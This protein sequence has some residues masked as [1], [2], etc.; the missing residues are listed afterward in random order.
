MKRLFNIFV[1]SLLPLVAVVGQGSLSG[2]NIYLNPGHG[3]FD[4]N[5]RSCWTIPVPSEWTDSAGYW[6][7][8]SNFV[9]GN[10]LRQML[11]DAGATVVYSREQN[12]SGQRDMPEALAR[13][14]GVPTSTI[15]SYFGGYD[16]RPSAGFDVE[17]FLQRYPQVTRAQYDSLLGGGDRYLSAIAE[18][19][20]AND[21][22]HFLSIHSNAVNKQTNYLLMLYHGSNGSPTVAQSNQMA[23]LAA[24]IQIKNELTVWSSASPQVYGDFTFYGDNSGLGVLRPLTVPHH[25]SEGSFHDYAPETHRLMNYDY[26]KLEA[27]RMFQFYHKWFNRTLPQTGTIAGFVKSQNEKVDELKERNWKYIAKSDDQWLPLN[28]ATISLLNSAGDQVLQSYTTDNWYNGI[29]AFYDLEPGNYKLS[30]H[31][32][33]YARDTVDVT[34]EA[35]E[36]EQVKFFVENKYRDVPDYSDPEQAAG[37]LP[38]DNYEFEQM[39]DTALEATGV[40]RMVARNGMLY[41]LYNNGAVTMQADNMSETPMSLPVPDGVTLTDIALTADGKPVGMTVNGTEL[42]MYTWDN[43]ILSIL[44]SATL[45]ESVGSRMAVS[46]ARWHTSY[47]L[48]PVATTGEGVV[49]RYNEEEEPQVSVEQ[50]ATTAEAGG[51]LMIAPDSTV[52]NGNGTFFRYAGHTYMTEFVEDNGAYGFV[53]KDVTNG[54]EDAPAVS[55][56]YPDGGMTGTATGY[57]AAM[58]Y[59]VGYNIF[60]DLFVEGIGYRHFRSLTQ[61]VADIYAGELNYVEGVGFSFRLN[62]DAMDVQIAIERDGETISSRSLGALEKGMHTVP[63][64]FDTEDFEAWSVTASARSVSYPVKLSDSSYPFQFNDGRGIAVDRTPESPFFGRIYVTEATGGKI[65]DGRTTTTG[66]YVLGSDFSDVTGQGNTSWNGN[67]A[68]GE[69]IGGD[70]YEWALSH[71]AVGP[72]GEVYLASSALKSAG[73]YMMDAGNPGADF[74]NIFDGKKSSKKGTLSDRETGEVI[75]NPVMDCVVLGKGEAKRLYTYDRRSSTAGVREGSIKRFDIGTRKLP[76]KTKPSAEEYNNVANDNHLQNGSGEIASD[77]RGGFWISQYRYSSTW[78]VPGLLHETAGYKNFNL[79]T[80]VN[81]AR[82]GGM[83][84]TTDGSTVAMGTDEGDVTVWSVEYDEAGVPTMTQL[85]VINWGN[86]EG[87]TL[88]VE[89]DA[90]GNLYIISPNN[91]RLM[92]YAMPKADNIF[93]TRVPKVR[94]AVEDPF[95]PVDDA[96]DAVEKDKVVVYPNPAADVIYVRGVER[97][98]CWFYDMSGKCVMKTSV[99]EEESVDVSA[100]SH[101]VYV[102]RVSDSAGQVYNVRIIK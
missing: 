79:S 97:G 4:S 47:Y 90:A 26:C 33:G 72:D 36:I 44:F 55:A 51:M 31:K 88:G 64:P 32:S 46:G 63:N 54:I 100:L 30:V 74:R 42:T 82:M 20:N 53:M 23:S 27:L 102:M 41:T 75:T 24:Q 15:A 58:S 68:W 22:D 59:S 66:V 34:V 37:T 50:T 57:K 29:F 89:F 93:T 87:N 17:A 77:G 70:E 35:E 39:K 48:E 21:V 38:L 60:V 80:N 69:T 56:I 96:L 101:G 99:A 62:D 10:I 45:P 7:S 61:P 43:N 6:E 12:N 73:V 11:E 81:G 84:V 94:S 1:F 85:F 92:V 95:G 52:Y 28:G 83:G 49:V 5:D 14:I 40:V 25:L 86:G 18:E 9:K 3:G 91:K 2:L 67:V 98:T 16:N 19:A 65:S 71:P 76:W 8:K 13:I 78:A